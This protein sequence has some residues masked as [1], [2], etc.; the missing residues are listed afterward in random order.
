MQTQLSTLYHDM[1]GFMGVDGLSI[2]L[3][4]VKF[5][6]HDDPV[7]PQVLQYQPEEL[8]LTSCQANK[9]ASLGDA[10]CLTYDNIGCV[11]AAISL[12]LVDQYQS[13]PIG[14][15]IVYT[16]I[17]RNQSGLDEQFVPPS[18]RDFTEGTVYACHDSGRQD[19]CLFGPNDSGRFKT[20]ETAR[21]AVSEMIAIQPAVMKAV[22]FYSIDFSEADLEPDV[23]VLSVRPVELAKLVQ[24]YQFETGERVESSMGPVR[25]VNSDLVVRP[26]LTGKINVSTYCVGARLIAQYDADQLGMG[27]PFSVYKTLVKALKDSKTGYP[28]HLYP[29]AAE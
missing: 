19:F 1:I 23:I 27:M 13:E 14:Q 20:V 9:Q 8:T 5:Y 25:V 24:A 16:D 29:G 28:F 26:Y 10:V 22:F 2:P 7:P 21:K 12:G 4:A 6:R 17:M 18:P 11:A 15:S 3:T